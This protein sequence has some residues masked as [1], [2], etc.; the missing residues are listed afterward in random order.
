MLAATLLLHVSGVAA[1]WALRHAN[2]WVPR[3]AGTGVA[4]FGLAL[5]GRLA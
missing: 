1:G 3:L 4:V 5:L 2:V